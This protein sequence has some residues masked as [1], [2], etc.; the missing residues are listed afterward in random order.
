MFGGSSV[1]V[2]HSY[3]TR[4]EGRALGRHA[5]A[6]SR[7]HRAGWPAVWCRPGVRRRAMGGAARGPGQPRAPVRVCSRERC[8]HR[9]E[10]VR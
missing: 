9:A 10:A 2:G 8:R 5:A 1:L 6:H 4:A 7:G 3:G